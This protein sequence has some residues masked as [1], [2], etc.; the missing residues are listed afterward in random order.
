MV[1]QVIPD[2]RSV[3]LLIAGAFQAHSVAEFIQARR[4][5][6]RPDNYWAELGNDGLKD[7]FAKT[8]S[9]LNREGW[10]VGNIRNVESRGNLRVK[11]LP[12]IEVLGQ[13]DPSELLQLPEQ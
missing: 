8:G 10:V 7:R 2:M 4:P 1:I 11:E 12:E 13:A 9:G 6:T 5:K 3:I